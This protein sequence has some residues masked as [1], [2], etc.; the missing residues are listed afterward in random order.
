MMVFVMFSSIRICHMQDRLSALCVG[1]VSHFPQSITFVLWYSQPESNSFLTLCPPNSLNSLLSTL[2]AY[3]LIKV[4]ELGTVLL[5]NNR[6]KCGQ[7]R[8]AE[9]LNWVLG[10]THSFPKKPEK[11]STEDL[12]YLLNNQTYTLLSEGIPLLSV[13]LKLG[14]WCSCEVE[15]NA[16][17]IALKVSNLCYESKHSFCDQCLFPEW[18]MKVWNIAGY[19]LVKD[20]IT[21]S[22]FA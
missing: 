7:E 22:C 18:Q 17:C 15:N 1:H 6:Q 5:P 10:N 19:S 4:R 3:G 20:K 2:F 13:S 14:V 11:D 12:W 8:A 9:T 16:L 21:V